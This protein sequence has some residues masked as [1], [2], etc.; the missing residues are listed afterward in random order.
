MQTQNLL[1]H[2]HG[3]IGS[4]LRNQKEKVRSMVLWIWRAIWWGLVIFPQSLKRS[5]EESTV[6]LINSE[7]ADS[8]SLVVQW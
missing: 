4:N 3:T 6:D 7:A 5:S 1:Q 8:V 2:T